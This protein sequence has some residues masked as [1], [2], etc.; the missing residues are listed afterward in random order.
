ML[1]SSMP[2][3]SAGAKAAS[4]RQAVVD[5]ETEAEVTQAWSS[6]EGEPVRD[7]YGEKSELRAYQKEMPALCAP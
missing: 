1:T 3:V 4:E 5:A 2:R 6:Y 7:L